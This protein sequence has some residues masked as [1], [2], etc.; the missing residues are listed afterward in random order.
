MARQRIEH[1]QAGIAILLDELDRCG[2]E[3]QAEALTQVGIRLLAAQTSA[4][5]K[6]F[7]EQTRLVVA[8]IEGLAD[9][10]E[11]VLALTGKAGYGSGDAMQAI[12]DGVGLTRGVV[13]DIEQ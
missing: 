10:A 9:Q 5:I 12:E 2:S 6:D 3:R 11:R 8:S 1:V 7:A 4:L 13:G